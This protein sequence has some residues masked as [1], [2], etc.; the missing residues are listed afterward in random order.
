MFFFLEIP[1]CEMTVIIISCKFTVKMGNI[2]LFSII[3]FWNITGNLP[4]TNTRKSEKDSFKFPFVI[5]L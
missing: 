2:W 4:N 5:L 3:I 1:A